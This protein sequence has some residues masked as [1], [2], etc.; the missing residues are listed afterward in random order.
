MVKEE[1]SVLIADG[2]RE[3]SEQL[4]DFLGHQ[5]DF[6]VKGTVDNGIDAI[7]MISEQK[8][9]IVILEMLLPKIDG[10]GVLKAVQSKKI[11]KRPIFLV[12]SSLK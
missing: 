9:D 5:K 6:V 3:I 10:I 4:S 7:D 11:E 8:P 1:I 12:L 2:N